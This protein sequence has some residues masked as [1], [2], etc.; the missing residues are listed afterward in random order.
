[1]SSASKETF[2]FFDN[3]FEELKIEEQIRKVTGVEYPIVMYSGYFVV[4][5]YGTA[6]H[7]HVDYRDCGI[8]AFT[9][10]TP[11]QIDE[12]ASTGHLLYKDV[13]DK[14]VVYRY[15]KGK[16]ILFGSDFL[17]STEPFKSE[18]KFIFLCFTFGTNAVSLYTSPSPRDS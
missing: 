18:Q 2:D 12:N 6:S 17:H 14:E 7:Y 3:C 15:R 8:N 4:R 10:M 16:A 5:S 1:M 11:I 13:F 9:L